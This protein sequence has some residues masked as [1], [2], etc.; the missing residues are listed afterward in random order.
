M[1]LWNYFKLSGGGCGGNTNPLLHDPNAECDEST[2][3]LVSPVNEHLGTALSA[4]SS[5]SRYH[6]QGVAIIDM[7]KN[8][9]MTLPLSTVYGEN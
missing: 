2:K 7:G 5:R 3:M 4:T 1:S 9:L 8:Y 6:Q